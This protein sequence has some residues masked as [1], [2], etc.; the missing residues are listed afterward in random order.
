MKEVWR[1]ERE[2]TDKMPLIK[3]IFFLL[4]YLH[5]NTNTVLNSGIEGKETWWSCEVNL[6]YANG[7]LGL[8]L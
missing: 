8:S 5:T 4:E 6:S 2:K 3:Y 7:G 1:L